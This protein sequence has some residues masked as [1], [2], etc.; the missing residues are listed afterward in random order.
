M[1]APTRPSPRPPFGPLPLTTPPKACAQ[2]DAA[3]RAPRGVHV[4]TPYFQERFDNLVALKDDEDPFLKR[5]GE[6]DVARRAG[7]SVRRHGLLRAREAREFARLSGCGAAAVAEYA[8]TRRLPRRRP[9]PAG[10]Q[11]PQSAGGLT[12]PFERSIW[13][14]SARS[15]LKGMKK[16]LAPI[17][18]RGLLFVLLSHVRL[19]S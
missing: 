11:G 19:S 2:A 7:F 6:G 18:V 17:M 13:N 12:R 16:A 14:G 8:G 4:A 10:R 5:V 1:R 3:P 15:F 9:R